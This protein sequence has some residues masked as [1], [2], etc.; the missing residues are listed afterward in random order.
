M[1]E[2]LVDTPVRGFVYEAAGTVPP[3]LLAA[4]AEAVR[5]AARRWRIPVEIAAADPSDPSAWAEEMAA[6]TNRVISLA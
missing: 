4:G 2:R 3:G 1:L 6:A 5:D